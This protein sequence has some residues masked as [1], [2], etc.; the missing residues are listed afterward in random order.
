[1]KRDQ[2]FG[3]IHKIDE[4][5]ARFAVKKLSAVSSQRSGTRDGLRKKEPVRREGKLSVDSHQSTAKE[6]RRPETSR[7]GAK[8]KKRM[9]Y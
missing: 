3:T 7:T 1:M 4:K 6:K 2:N 9:D 5:T 8:G